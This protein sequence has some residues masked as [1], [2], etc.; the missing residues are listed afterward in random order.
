MLAKLPNEYS[1]HYD[2]VCATECALRKSRG[3]QAGI[4]GLGVGV[5]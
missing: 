1:Q 3:H 2:D 4:R 5:G